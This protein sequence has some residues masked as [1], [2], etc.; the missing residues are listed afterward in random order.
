MR[1]TGRR[2]DVDVADSRDLSAEPGGQCTSGA[3]RSADEP[4]PDAD[5][6]SRRGRVRAI[7]TAERGQ[8][9]GDRSADVEEQDRNESK[10]DAIAKGVEDRIYTLYLRMFDQMYPM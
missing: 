9:L 10:G 4:S 1:A 3:Q 2:K 7:G 8:S 5:A 6:K